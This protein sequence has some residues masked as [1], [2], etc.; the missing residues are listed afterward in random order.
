MGVARRIARATARPLV[1]ESAATRAANVLTRLAHEAEGR[2]RQ[3]TARRAQLKTEFPTAVLEARPPW[4]GIERSSH[5]HIPAMISREEKDYYAWIGHFYRGNGEVIELGPWLGAS[6]VCI[7]DSLNA[8][9]KFSGRRMVVVDDFVWRS[10]WMDKFVVE[11]DRP[12]N[13]ESFRH[14]FDRY[15]NGYAAHM[16]VL[17]ARI[18]DYDGNEFLPRLAWDRGPIEMAFIDCGRSIS[19]NQAWW[20]I[21]S[22]HFIDGALL[23]MQDWQTHKRVPRQWFNQ[24]RDF[25]DMHAAQLDLVHELR[26]GGVA[27]FVY[28]N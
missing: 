11:A 13:H 8:N 6:T 18:S 20:D 22:P 4:L 2:A 17:T 19:A 15:T 10:S 9:P 16:D 23:V 14:L 25:T 26:D 28:R 21:L 7:L 1:T 27:S 24:M 12:L 5:D 3:H